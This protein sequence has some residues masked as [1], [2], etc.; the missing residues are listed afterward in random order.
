MA[1]DETKEKISRSAAGKPGKN[2][3]NGGGGK[4]QEEFNSPG[5]P[6]KSDQKTRQMKCEAKRN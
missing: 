5:S 4:K 6:A 1:V 2:S 3:S